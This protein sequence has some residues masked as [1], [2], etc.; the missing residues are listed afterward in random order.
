MMNPLRTT[1]VSRRLWTRTTQALGKLWAGV[2]SLPDRHPA[3]AERD[4][5]DYPRYPWF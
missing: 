3:A 5:E 1:G 2:I 4:F